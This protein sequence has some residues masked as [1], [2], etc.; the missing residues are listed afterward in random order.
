NHDKIKRIIHMYRENNNVTRPT[1]EKVFMAL[2]IPSAFG[3]VG[4]KGKLGKA[5]EMYEEFI[6]RYQHTNVERRERLFGIKRSYRQRVVLVAQARKQYPDREPLPQDE[7]V[8]RRIETKKRK[9]DRAN[10]K[11]PLQYWTGYL[12]VKAHK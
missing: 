9:Y 3:R 12:T 8:E 5:D 7:A 6:S 10:H 2:Y 1:T 4:R 11:G